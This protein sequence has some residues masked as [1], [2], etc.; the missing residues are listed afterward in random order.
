M[1]SH[2]D[3]RPRSEQDRLDMVRSRRLQDDMDAFWREHPALYRAIVQTGARRRR[4]RSA[5]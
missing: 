5:K 4:R 1:D 2:D 3:G